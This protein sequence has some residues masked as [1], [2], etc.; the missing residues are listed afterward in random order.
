MKTAPKVFKHIYEV[1]Q[2]SLQGFKE[3]VYG[4]DGRNMPKPHFAFDIVP[5][6]SKAAF[7]YNMVCTLLPYHNPD[8]LK[9][10][11]WVSQWFADEN[12]GVDMRN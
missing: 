11:E 10:P 5:M 7:F 2:L 3:H 8:N 1:Y 6:K 4:S 12:A 9:Q